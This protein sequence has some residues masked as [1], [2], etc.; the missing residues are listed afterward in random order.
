MRYNISLYF[1]NWHMQIIRKNTILENRRF[2]R[3]TSY[4]ILIMCLLCL[5]WSVLVSVLIEKT[6]F[7]CDSNSKAIFTNYRQSI[8][9]I[10]VKHLI[11]FLY[12][13]SLFRYSLYIYEYYHIYYL[14]YKTYRYL[15]FFFPHR[16]Y[17]NFCSITNCNV[18]KLAKAFNIQIR[19]SA[20][21]SDVNIQQLL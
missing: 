21:D 4:N 16:K 18:I 6:W 15:I 5:K 20:A 9:N 13:L 12:H 8:F 1:R 10:Y 14:T 3:L 19:I 17:N 11:Y 2:I 7:W